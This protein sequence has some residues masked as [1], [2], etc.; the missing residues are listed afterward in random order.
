MGILSKYPFWFP[1]R[2]FDD[3]VGLHKNFRHLEDF[4]RV[5]DHGS[6]QHADI[7]VAPSDAYDSSGADYFLSGTNDHILMQTIIDIAKTDNL[8]VHV[9]SG[10]VNVA[11]VIDVGSGQFR[12]SG[13]GMGNTIWSAQSWA[14]A[15][16]V[17]R[18]EEA[19]GEI[20]YANDFTIAGN[21]NVDSGYFSGTNGGT[22][23]WDRI[24]VKNTNAAGILYDRTAT[25]A[26]WYNECLIHD[27]QVGIVFDREDSAQ[28]TNCTVQSNTAQG[29]RAGGTNV[30]SMRIIGNVIISNG[31]GI[32]SSGAV[33]E[34]NDCII[35]GNVIRNNN[36]ESIALDG[37]GHIIIGNVLE[38]NGTNAPSATGVIMGNNVGNTATYL[39]HADLGAVT[40][41]QHHTEAHTVAS[42]SDTT[43]TGAELETLT[44]ASNADALHTHSEHVNFSE[45]GILAT[46]T[47][48]MRWYPPYNVT[49]TDVAIMVG[50]APTGATLIVDVNK[51]G[52][53][54][55]TTQSNRPT[56]AISGFHDVS[57]TPEV[58][59]LTGDTD[60]LTWDID[61][62]G[63]TVPGYDLVIQI[64]FVAA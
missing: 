34:A 58:T 33:Q 16:Y 35:I 53:T 12:L 46:K 49:L 42:H 55:F 45:A 56:I 11:A 5:I 59:A 57:G 10:T 4:L 19:G 14:G 51:N 8:W 15:S 7:T 22:C 32:E 63:S 40:S 29:I 30:V 24:E 31:S 27:N 6:A 26:G 36:S 62:I 50:T 39:D 20:F 54:I 28:I 38:G 41:D 37:S 2:K 1:V 23:R 61:Q 44:D 60:Y 48:T 43:A 25:S 21:S 9:L 52:T 13:N 47:G 18:G 64:R 17:F 3:P